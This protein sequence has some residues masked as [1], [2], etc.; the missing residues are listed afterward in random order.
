MGTQRAQNKTLF[1]LLTFCRFTQPKRLLINWVLGIVEE[2]DLCAS[3]GELCKHSLY[4]SLAPMIPIGQH[5]S[6]CKNLINKYTCLSSLYLRQEVNTMLLGNLTTE[7]CAHSSSDLY[8]I[9]P[10][11]S[12]NLLQQAISQ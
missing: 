4:I 11:V 8:E 6:T 5:E 7:L 1:S 3:G 10:L 9:V 2:G 12:V